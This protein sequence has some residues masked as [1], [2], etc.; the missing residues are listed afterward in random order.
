MIKATS[1]KANTTKNNLI[2]KQRME[3]FKDFSIELIYKVNNTY[4]GSEGID[5]NDKLNHFNWCFDV[6]C[7]LFKTQGVDFKNNNEIRDYFLDIL[8]KNYYNIDDTQ[9]Q[10]ATTSILK[11]LIT[12]FS[13]NITD[14]KQITIL[15]NIFKK[16]NKSIAI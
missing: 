11:S 3:L 15:S 2:L 8:I 1:N 5:D 12:L 16:F 9:K 10:I 13:T 4:P 6:N 14:S 7:N